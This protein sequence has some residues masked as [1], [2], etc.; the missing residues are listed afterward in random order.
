VLVQEPSEHCSINLGD[1]VCNCGEQGV[2]PPAKI[3]LEVIID[4]DL[5]DLSSHHLLEKIETVVCSEISIV[6]PTYLHHLTSRISSFN[7]RDLI[8]TT[9]D[10]NSSD[11][12][13]ISA[14]TAEKVAHNLLTRRNGVPG[15]CG[16]RTKVTFNIEDPLWSS[17]DRKQLVREVCPNILE[18][19]EVV[20]VLQRSNL[21]QVGVCHDRSRVG[22]TVV[23]IG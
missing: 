6:P 21:G 20:A 3:A 5:Y 14:T 2:W 23:T 18:G 15:A 22:V 8:I 13:S 19:S 17:C 9:H 4:L 10:H 7:F 11:L 16:T 1:Q 12:A